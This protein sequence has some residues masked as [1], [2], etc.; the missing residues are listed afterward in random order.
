MV[1]LLVHF[2]PAVPRGQSKD[3]V[4]KEGEKL[5]AVVSGVRANVVVG[6]VMVQRE[7]LAFP[8]ATDVELKDGDVLISE[9]DGRAEILLQ[10]GNYLRITA[11]T[12][13]H[14]ISTQYDKLRVHLESGGVAFELL[15]Q[16]KPRFYD[17]FS[18]YLIRVTTA[19]SEAMLSESGVYRFN[20]TK[21]G[22]ELL[23]RK[24]EAQLNNQHVKEKHVG[25]ELGGVTTTGEFDSKIEDAFD[26]YVERANQLTQLNHQLKKETP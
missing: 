21:D 16:E 13:L 24:G 19:R 1:L 18:Y 5:E 14:L 20:L 11:N 4:V 8:L 26:S 25:R 23:V 17:T 9:Q 2:S 6:K 22:P 3:Q 7:G 15:K 10:P 12:E